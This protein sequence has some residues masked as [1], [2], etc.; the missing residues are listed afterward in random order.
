MIEV[1]KQFHIETRIFQLESMNDPEYGLTSPQAVFNRDQVPIELRSSACQTI[2]EKGK[3]VIWDGVGGE[4]D[5]KRF[6]TLNL[7]IPMEPREDGKNQS[8]W[9][10]SLPNFRPPRYYPPRLTGVVQSIDR[11]V[12][13]HYKRGV[14]T[15]GRPRRMSSTDAGSRTWEPTGTNDECGKKDPDYEVRRKHT[16]SSVE[17]GNVQKSIHRNRNL[18]PD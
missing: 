11:H 12:G 2:D 14:Y 8:A 6:C 16:R 5:D 1:I 3:D 13:I 7:W 18:A 10:T 9:K 4:S 15:H 17:N